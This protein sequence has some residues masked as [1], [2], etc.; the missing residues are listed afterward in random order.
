MHKIIGRRQKTKSVPASVLRFDQM[1]YVQQN[2]YFSLNSYANSSLETIPISSSAISLQCKNHLFK[3]FHFSVSFTVYNIRLLIIRLNSFCIAV[4]LSFK[5]SNIITE[6][7]HFH[8]V[9]L[10]FDWDY[11]TYAYL[12]E[13]L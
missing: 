12:C 8:S 1:E 4:E 2:F 11:S 6:F 5:L 13:N 7:C 3:C 9:W 10:Y